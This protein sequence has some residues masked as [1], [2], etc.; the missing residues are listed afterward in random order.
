METEKRTARGENPVGELERE[1]TFLART[2]DALQRKRKYPL[3][4]AHYIIIQMIM[5]SGPQTV[6]NLAGALFLD[7]STVV[8]QTAVMEKAGLIERRANPDDG[9]SQLLSVTPAGREKAQAMQ[10]VRIERIGKLIERWSGEEKSLF[11]HLLGRLNRELAQRGLAE[12][13]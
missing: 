13:E 5:G 3:E 4:R 2:L 6:S 12:A 11:N 7:N 10:R 9:R 8:R 1:L